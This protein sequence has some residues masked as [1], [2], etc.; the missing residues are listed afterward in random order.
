MAAV[1]GAAQSE[2][3]AR[4]AAVCGGALAAAATQADDSKHVYCKG[5]CQVYC[6]VSY[7]G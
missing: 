3:A 5:N 6:Q 1:A 4:L 2:Q 7:T